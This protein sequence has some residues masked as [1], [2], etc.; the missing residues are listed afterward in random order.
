MNISPGRTNPP[1]KTFLLVQSAEEFV[2]DHRLHD[3]QLQLS[4]LGPKGHRDVVASEPGRQVVA[5]GWKAAVAEG[6]QWV[7]V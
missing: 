3:V 6:I 1:V 7:L 2:N 4:C 5:V